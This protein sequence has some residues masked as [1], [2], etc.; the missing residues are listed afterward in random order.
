MG[1]L[2]CPLGTEQ[3]TWPLDALLWLS[4]QAFRKETPKAGLLCPSLDAWV[5]PDPCL[6][7]LRSLQ[8]PGIGGHWQNAGIRGTVAIAVSPGV[9]VAS[10]GHLSC[11]W[12]EQGKVG[13]VPGGWGQP[14][15]CW[16][17]T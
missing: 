10:V 8:A 6:R 3:H 17:M 12:A 14:S 11:V 13:T 9:E 2:G 4:A 16:V 1:T 7:A 15:P 5:A